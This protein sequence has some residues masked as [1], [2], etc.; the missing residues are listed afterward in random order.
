[1]LIKSI[2]PGWSW[3]LIDLHASSIFASEKWWVKVDK[4][5][6]TGE[7][8]STKPLFFIFSWRRLFELSKLLTISL[9]SWTYSSKDALLSAF[10]FYAL[11]FR[12]TFSSTT[13][14]RPTIALS[15]SLGSFLARTVLIRSGTSAAFIFFITARKRFCCISLNRVR[16]LMSWSTYLVSSAV[17]LVKLSQ[18]TYE[19]VPTCA[20]TASK[21]AYK[22]YIFAS[23]LK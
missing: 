11:W 6:F 4:S 10:R 12:T 2:V 1:M 22:S 13:V 23:M 3:T 15:A 8:Y 9:L 7:V 16:E 14:N 19:S 18:S 21:L 20:R 17:D 5:S